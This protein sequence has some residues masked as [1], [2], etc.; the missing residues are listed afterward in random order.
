MNK[1]IPTIIGVPTF[2]ALFPNRISLRVRR[3]VRLLP[4]ICLLASLVTLPP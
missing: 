2:E 3:S 4:K 1:M